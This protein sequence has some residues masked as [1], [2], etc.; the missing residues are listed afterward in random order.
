MGALDAILPADERKQERINVRLSRSVKKTLDYAAAV[1]GRSASDFIVS[2]ALKAA[3]E[4]IEAHEK[5]KLIAE[6]RELFAQALLN[7]PR[8]NKAL[9]DA[10]KR[11]KKILK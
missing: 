8:P 3:H 5:M 6:D 10:A 7:P 1:S 2:S 4:A 9:R 11:Y